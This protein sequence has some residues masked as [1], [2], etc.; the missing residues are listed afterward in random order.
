M[1]NRPYGRP[2]KEINVIKE[3]LRDIATCHANQWWVPTGHGHV[4]PR[5]TQLKE[6][7]NSITY[8][9]WA[10]WIHMM[11]MTATIDSVDE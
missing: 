9:C 3:I 4:N 5:T 7:N 11:T 2:S 10:F 6:F 8:R 1:P